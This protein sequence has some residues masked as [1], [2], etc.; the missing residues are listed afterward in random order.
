MDEATQKPV[1]DAETLDRIRSI[2]VPPAWTD[3]WICADPD[4]HMQA[5]GRDARGR[6]QYRYHP[7]F[8]AERERTKFDELVAFGESLGWLRRTLDDDLAGDGLTHERIV[9]LVVSLLECTHIRVGNECYVAAN[10]TYGLTTLRSRHVTVRGST[11]RIKFAGQ[12]RSPSRRRGDRPADRAARPR[13]PGPAR[14]VAVPVGGRRRGPAAGHVDRGQR[15]PPPQ[16]RSRRD[17]QDV[18]HLGRHVAR[19]VRLRRSCR[20]RR[21]LAAATLPSRRWSKSSPTSWATRRPW[22]ATRT[23]TRWCSRPT[24]RARC[25]TCGERAASGPR[26]AHRRGA[27]RCSDCCAAASSAGCLVPVG[28]FG[29]RR[30][31][32]GW[33]RR[34]GPGRARRGGPCP[35]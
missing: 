15:L 6:K 12:G 1:T 30:T 25:T 18:P 16:D 14:P 13:L 31:P 27:P 32:R 24:R 26:R 22:P 21:R 2:A 8:R 17:G 34:R 7:E 19:G 29:H 3:V 20:R 11:V 23:S 35:R 33:R 10:G 9:A 28:R 5:T 4:G